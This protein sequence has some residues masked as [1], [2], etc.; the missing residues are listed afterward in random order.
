LRPPQS[1]RVRQRH[2]DGRIDHVQP[3]IVR[4]RR[5]LAGGSARNEKIDAG[6]HLPRHQ[7]AQGSVINRAI[8]MK[9]SYE[10][11]TTATE[12]HA[13]KI[14]RMGCEGTAGE[15]QLPPHI[16]EIVE[17]LLAGNP[18]RR[19]HGAIGESLAG[20]GIVTQFYNKSC[21]RRT[22]RTTSCMPT[23]SPSRNEVIS[24]PSL[25]AAGLADHVL[26]GDGRSR[27]RVLFLSVMSLEDLPRVLMP[28]SGSRRARHV[29]ETEFTPT[30]KFAA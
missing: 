6:L 26:N 12:L 5:R 8:L 10:R 18:L 2:L 15:L 9:G 19:A 3:F 17:T 7:V 14:T 1:A 22:R 4:E 30:E 16:L 13:N 21:Q 24:R 11:C 20:L 23:T 28:Q 27:R 29:E 25:P